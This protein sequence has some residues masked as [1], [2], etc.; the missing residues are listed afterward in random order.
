MTG[1]IGFLLVW[2]VPFVLGT[3]ISSACLKRRYGYKS[4]AIGSGYLLGF[5]ITLLTQ[6]YA[7][8][9][10]LS[11]V[12]MTE[13]VLAGVISFFFRAKRCTIEEQRLEKAPPNWAY[14][15]GWFLVVVLLSRWF[16]TY[17][18][19]THFIRKESLVT[20]TNTEPL[21]KTIQWKWGL[22]ITDWTG[23]TH[24]YQSFFPDEQKHL[25]QVPWLVISLILGL[26]VFGGLRYLGSRL[27]PA[28]F[29][30]YMV[31]SLPFIIGV[32]IFTNVFSLTM[33]T[34]YLWLLI[35]LAVL[36]GFLEK[37]PILLIVFGLYIVSMYQYWLFFIGVVV[38]T[39]LF[40]RYVSVLLAILLSMCLFLFGF[41]LMGDGIT[42][43]HLA[44]T[45]RQIIFIENN[46]HF[47]VLSALITIPVFGLCHRRHDTPALE[48]LLIGSLV[49]FLAMFGVLIF[50][51]Y[52][53][54]N[55]LDTMSMVACFTP[56]LCLIPVIVYQLTNEE[57]DTLPVI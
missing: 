12:L 43:H 13:M 54:N 57:K 41:V 20:L 53:I 9:V 18:D 7:T 4:L 5:L 21:W 16:M 37:R 47:A 3:V 46:W 30:A 55:Y 35:L 52:D 6:K 36:V 56:L 25:A 45:L 19:L 11:V 29:G 22:T 39:Y 40:G 27:L 10:G 24:Y 51:K 48:L 50:A 38:I 44:D 42:V 17:W 8:S 14:F 1:V 15:I 33:I 23:L 26:I 32:D 49:T 28:T 34:Y 2:L 31:L